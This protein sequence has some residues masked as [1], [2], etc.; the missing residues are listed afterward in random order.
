EPLHQVPGT[1]FF[2]RSVRLPAA[3]RLE[4]SFNIFDDQLEDPLNAR[5]ADSGDHS[6]VLTTAGWTEP[7]HLREPEGARGR[8]ETFNWTSEI[9]ENERE[10]KIYVPPD[11]EASDERYPVVVVNYG[12]QA[13]EQGRWA[14]SLD[15][16]I[17]ESV[18]PLIAV[19][20]PR[21]DFNEYGPRLA[22]FTDAIA[23]EL[24]PAVDERYRTLSGAEHRAMT[25][26]ASGAFASAFLALEK[27][28]LIGKVALQSFYFRDEAEEEL[29]ALIEAGGAGAA[30]FYVEW[31][32]NDIEVARA[33][34]HC[35]AHSRELAELLGNKGFSLVTQEV[36]DS[37]GW[38]S[39]RTRTDRILE[40]FFPPK[41]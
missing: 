41:D 12:D 21:V 23:R 22:Q 7:L 20:L 29:R 3:S 33:G 24:L 2:F 17:G 6:S 5:L 36:A 31:S 13:L 28:G 38:G 11:Y 14:H 35:E 16:L 4:Y 39:W 9:L 27:P 1:Q 34:I 37:A 18:A 40:L 26:I 30:S 15:N 8:L 19:F 10:I 32:L 25:G